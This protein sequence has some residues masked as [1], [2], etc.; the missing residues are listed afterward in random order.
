MPSTPQ[1]QARH[2]LRAVAREGAHY[3]SGLPVHDDGPYGS[4]EP[5]V[6]HYRYEHADYLYTEEYIAVD[7]A[8]STATLAVRW[9][10]DGEDDVG[11]YQP[12]TGPDNPAAGYGDVYLAETGGVAQNHRRAAACGT[13]AA[14]ALAA[15]TG[16]QG[17]HRGHPDRPR[18]HRLGDPRPGR[19]HPRS[20]RPAISTPRARPHA[21]LGGDAAPHTVV[22]RRRPRRRRLA[23]G[24][25]GVRGAAARLRRREPPGE[26]EMT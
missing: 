15:P 17:H 23:G 9:V 4:T 24:G 6:Y 26:E 3:T 7:A 18:R 22:L 11:P 5:A 16:D 25:R 1:S 10:A 8:R 13:R 21:H 19:H 20:R 14:L 12:P 2:W